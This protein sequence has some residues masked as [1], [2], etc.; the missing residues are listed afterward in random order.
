MPWDGYPPM[1]GYY[2]FMGFWMTLFWLIIIIV[3]AYLIYR[4]IKSDRT[5]ASGR[6]TE[7]TAD[8]ILAERYA[9]GELTRDEYL[10]MKEDIKGSSEKR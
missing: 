1:M 4:L 6:T 7:R 3:A 2:P 5:L 9:K 10:K 8:D